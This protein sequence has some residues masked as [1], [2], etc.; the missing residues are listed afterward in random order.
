LATPR[1]IR[2]CPGCR[3]ARSFVCAGSFRVNA[4]KKAIDVWLNYRCERCD[5][6]WKC[7]VLERVPV[8]SVAADQLNAFFQDDPVMVRRYALDIRHL[9][10]QDVRIE[11]SPAVLVQRDPKTPR[12]ARA[13]LYIRLDVPL[14]CAIRLDRLLAQELG[15]R[16][17][18]LQSLYEKGGLS[19]LPARRKPLSAHVHDG[20]R[21]WVLPRSV[22]YIAVENGSLIS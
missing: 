2:H 7:P 13:P 19:V 5:E 18:E 11:V 15:L 21:L 10:R 9:A 14:P 17:A 3:A 6:N 22:G 8:S 20:Q 1:L 16:R 4:Q 12:D